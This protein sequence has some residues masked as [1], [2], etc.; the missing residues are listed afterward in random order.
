M[1]DLEYRFTLDQQA[2]GAQVG[3]LLVREAARL[4]R[5]IAAQARLNAPV[6]TGFLAR[7]IEE[8]PIVLVGAFRVESGVTA[9]AKYAKFVHDGTRRM[10]ARP[11]LRNAADQVIANR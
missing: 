3:P 7:S 8:D 6:K 2:L 9:K 5:R 10:R 4:T 11:F 1:A